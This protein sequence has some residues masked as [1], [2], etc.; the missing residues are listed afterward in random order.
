MAKPRTRK[1]TWRSRL[2][3]SWNEFQ[4]RPAGRRFQSYYNSRH[5]GH[6]FNGK[7]LLQLGAGLLLLIAGGILLVIPGP[8]IPVV[9]A[10]AVL[11][12][13]HVKPAAKLLDWVDVH[14][15]R[16][17]RACVREWKEASVLLK[18]LMATGAGMAAATVAYGA[19]DLLL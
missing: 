12:A 16:A 9:V 18:S 2:K 11:I 17:W 8:G 10:G 13:R 4:S 5:R 19:F 1:R 14:V 3:Q 6:G 7:T 15:R